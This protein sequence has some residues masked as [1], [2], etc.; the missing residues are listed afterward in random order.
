MMENNIRHLQAN[1]E[2]SKGIV[3]GESFQFHMVL[4]GQGAISTVL[5]ERGLI[6]N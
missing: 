1:F 6:A 4:Q 3:L 2:N 5:H